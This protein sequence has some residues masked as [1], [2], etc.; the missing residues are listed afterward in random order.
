MVMWLIKQI[1]IFRPEAIQELEPFL[2][3]YTDAELIVGEHFA[4]ERRTE[5]ILSIGEKKN[6]Q[7]VQRPGERPYQIPIIYAIYEVD[8]SVNPAENAANKVKIFSITDSV[9]DI[10]KFLA[11][12]AVQ[13]IFVLPIVTTTGPLD[14]YYAGQYGPVPDRR[15]E[16][17]K[18][19]KLAIIYKE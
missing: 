8:G 7:A 15:P 13:K 18:S 19:H 6:L 9:I 5:N 16:N 1:K 3:Q 2:V 10:N 12:H 11:C 17:V 4:I 14:N